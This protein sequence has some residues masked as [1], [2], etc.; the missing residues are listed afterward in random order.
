M[1]SSQVRIPDAL[2]AAGHQSPTP[3][4]AR[5][6]IF[7]SEGDPPRS[8]FCFNG[9]RLFMLLAVCFLGR[10]VRRLGDHYYGPPAYLDRWHQGEGRPRLYGVT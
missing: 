4:P 3:L 1:R 7:R 6:A 2:F 5:V 9:G 10:V 8:G